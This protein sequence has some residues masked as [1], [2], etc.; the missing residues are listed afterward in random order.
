MYSA[1]RLD[2][3]SHLAIALLPLSMKQLTNWLQR[4]AGDYPDCHPVPRRPRRPRPPQH[5]PPRPRQQGS[6]SSRHRPRPIGSSAK[7][8]GLAKAAWASLPGKEDKVKDEDKSTANR[9]SETGHRSAHRDC[10]RQD[11]EKLAGA[12]ASHAERH[13]CGWAEDEMT[14]GRSTVDIELR[15]TGH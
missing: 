14:Q 3:V 8:V 10:G 12:N 2:Y 6:F 13:F 5:Y 4:Y 1:A 9:R 11:L 7:I 15:V